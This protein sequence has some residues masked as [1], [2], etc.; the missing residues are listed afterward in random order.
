MWF[1]GSRRRLDR[2]EGDSI[3]SH[4]EEE[5]MAVYRHGQETYSVVASCD[6]STVGL[7]CIVRLVVND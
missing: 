6:L 7:I 1:R 5:G 4:I 2:L 3:M